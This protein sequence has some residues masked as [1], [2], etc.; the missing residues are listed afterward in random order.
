MI[1]LRRGSGGGRPRL[2]VSAHLDT[3]F[4]E[5]TDVTAKQRDGAIMAPGW[6]RALD[7]PIVPATE[8]AV[9]AVTRRPRPTFA[10]WSTDSNIAMSLGVPVVTIGGGGE[11]AVS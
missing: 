1:A 11:R 6:H 9:P 8:R 4:P 10:G 2:V 3:V 7:L 5:G